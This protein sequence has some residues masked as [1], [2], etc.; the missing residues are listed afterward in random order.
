MSFYRYEVIISRNG[1]HFGTMD[2]K[3][4][5]NED[6]ARRKYLE[7]CDMFREDDGH[8]KLNL[9]SWTL[10]IGTEL[11]ETEFNGKGEAS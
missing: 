2:L 3:C 9:V 4:E 6:E 7:L 10:P 11:T 5:Y 1:R 8:W